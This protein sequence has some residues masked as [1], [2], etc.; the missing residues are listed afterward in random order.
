MAETKADVLH[1]GLY[2]GNPGTGF[3]EI[4]TQS[5]AVFRKDG[6]APRVRNVTCERVST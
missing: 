6:P 5:G 2:G 3:G 1:R 4:E